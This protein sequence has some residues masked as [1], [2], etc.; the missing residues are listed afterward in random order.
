MAA[1]PFPSGE[2]KVRWVSSDWLADHLEDDMVI[3]DT[4]PN[5]HDYIAE[6]IPGAVY[7]NEGL[8]RVN[9]YGFPQVFVPGEA[10]EPIIGRLGVEKGRPALVY[11]GVGAVKKWGDGLEQSKWAYALARYGHDK[12]YVLDGGLDKWKAEGRALTQKFPSKDS[13]EFEVEVNDDYFVDME[14]VKEMKD[15]GDVIVLD[16]RPP[17][18]YEGKGVWARPGHIPGSV[19]LPWASLMDPNNTRLYKP[20]DEV[21]RLAEAV[22][23]TKDKIVICSCGTGREATLEFLTFKWLLDYPS[24]HIYEGAFTEWSAYPENPVVTGKNP[25]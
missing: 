21:R 3:I 13:S 12:I 11:T 4:Q 19:N 14:D 17:A 18:V 20:V 2:G 6:H 16:A 7:A 22:G 25:Y 1:H 24:V 8:L 5:I 15:K 10:I 23:A 9:E